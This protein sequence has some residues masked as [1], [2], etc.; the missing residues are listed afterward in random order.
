MNQRFSRDLVYAAGLLGAASLVVIP[1]PTWLLDVLILTNIA[2]SALLFLTAALS[3]SV[4]QLLLFPN[5]ILFF[6]LLRLG[7]NVSTTRGILSQASAGQVVDAFGSFVARGDVVIGMLMFVIITIV[8]FLVISKGAERVA[9]VGAR[10]ALDAMPGKQMSIDADLRAGAIS[11]EEARERRRKLGL[12]SQIQGSMDGAMK[13]VK[14]DTIAGLIITAINLVA[15]LAIGALRF[16]MPVDEAASVYALLT[17]GDGL[18]SQVS[19]LFVAAAAGIFVTKV[20]DPGPDEREPVSIA[21]AVVSQF[22]V[23][24]EVGLVLGAGLLGLALIPGMPTYFLVPVGGLVFAAPMLWRHVEALYDDAGEAEELSLGRDGRGSA[25]PYLPRMPATVHPICFQVSPQVASVLQIRGAEDD[26]EAPLFRT[27]FPQ[28]QEAAF[29]ET[30]V[31]IPTPFVHIS[32]TESAGECVIEVFGVPRRT[33]DLSAEH[34]LVR[35]SPERLRALGFEGT[36]AAFP[37]DEPGQTSATRIPAADAELVEKMGLRAWSVDALLCLELLR[38]LKGRLHQFVTVESVSKRLDELEKTHPRLVSE[39][40]PKMLTLSRFAGILRQLVDGGVPVLDLA[41]VLEAILESELARSS[42]DTLLV[43]VARR[44]L[45]HT[46]TY[47][48]AR[49]EEVLDA[50]VLAPEI[51]DWLVDQ[52]GDHSAVAEPSTMAL[53]P[54]TAT[55]LKDEVLRVFGDVRRR[56][57]NCVLLTDERVR[58]WVRQILKTAGREIPVLSVGDLEPELRIQVAATV[59][60]HG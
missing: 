51:E 21:D 31:H 47:K 36:P 46:I 12:E 16:E 30:G 37:G 10:F 14:G 38:L 49:G 13:F 20:I 7:L 41:T 28:M 40:V 39:T 23:T 6:T 3:T 9:E 17:I 33:L 59:E 45:R 52:L 54:S 42:H 25:R 48:H 26:T 56:R 5:A 15:G 60:A 58:G 35:Q 2:F 53:E 11:D 18:S 22:F 24:P 44:A 4:H 27:V 32:P 34:V 1:L 8:Q 55:R 29:L 19:A 57:P 43:E 50:V